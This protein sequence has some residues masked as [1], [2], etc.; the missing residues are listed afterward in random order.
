MGSYHSREVSLKRTINGWKIRRLRHES[1]VQSVNILVVKCLLRRSPLRRRGLFILFIP[2]IIIHYSRVM[3]T[4]N[5]PGFILCS[6]YSSLWVVLVLLMSWLNRVLVIIMGLWSLHLWAWSIY[7]LQF[8]GYRLCWPS[9]FVTYNSSLGDCYDITWLGLDYGVLIVRVEFHDLLWNA[10]VHA[11]V[12]I[13][14]SN[15]LLQLYHALV[16]Y[17]SSLVIIYYWSLV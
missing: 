12:L 6:P 17:I 9:S 4:I 8:Y 2:I 15:H 10:I 7:L 14:V 1:H 11:N 16:R 5:K 13:I 3:L